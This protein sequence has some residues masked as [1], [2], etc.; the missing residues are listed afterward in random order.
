M[1]DELQ[2]ENGAYF[3]AISS[4]KLQ[5]QCHGMLCRWLKAAWGW[6]GSPEKIESKSVK[7]LFLSIVTIHL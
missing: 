1:Y 5:V 3:C 7:S 6:K 2:R 4:L